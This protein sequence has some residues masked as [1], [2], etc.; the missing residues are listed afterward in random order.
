MLPNFFHTQHLTITLL[1]IAGGSGIHAIEA[2]KAFP[3]L[4]GIIYERPFVCVV[5]QEF[6]ENFQLQNSIKTVEGDM[7]K[8]TFPSSDLHFYSDIFHDWQ[9]EKCE[10]LAKKSYESLPIGGRIIIHELLFDEDKSSPLAT[11]MYNVVMLLCTNKGQQYSAKEIL[12]IL[13]KVG[14]KEIQIIP[15]G[16]GS[17]SIVT[18]VK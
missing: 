17:W 12:A 2:V 7:W 8:D 1:D 13:E 10:F 3:R 16:F 9:V 4:Q 18:G 11:A 14:F 15:T 5:A 6:I